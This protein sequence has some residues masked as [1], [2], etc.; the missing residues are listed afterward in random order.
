MYTRL[1]ERGY[2][3]FPVNPNADQVEGDRSYPNLK[4][5][6]GGVK[7]VVIGTR[8]EAA[9]GTIRECVELGIR[10]VW[11]HRSFGGGSISAAATGCLGGR[12][13]YSPAHHRADFLRLEPALTT[14]ER[15]IA[16]RGR[17]STWSSA[18]SRGRLRAGR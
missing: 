9:E 7:A 12:A 5:I 3:V 17:P 11:M 13:P 10:H 15:M 6:P 18:T 1:R 14:G 16:D 8:P 2:H 4:S